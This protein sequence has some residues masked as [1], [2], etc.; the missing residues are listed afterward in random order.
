MILQYSQAYL[1]FEE[2]EPQ[3]VPSAISPSG[4]AA[5]PRPAVRG[6]KPRSVCLEEW[7]ARTRRKEVN[8]ERARQLINKAKAKEAEE[9]FQQYVIQGIEKR[10]KAAVWTTVLAEL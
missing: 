4:I 3:A 10:R 7:Y 2:E 5:R 9:R 1:L 6:V 8:M